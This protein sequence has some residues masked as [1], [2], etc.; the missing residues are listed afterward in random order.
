MSI[1]ST[2][3]L[4]RNEAIKE[5]WQVFKTPEQMTNRELEKA[6]FDLI[7]SEYNEDSPLNNYIVTDS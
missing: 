5:L 3:T 7:G 1:Y 4:T 2:R 6:M